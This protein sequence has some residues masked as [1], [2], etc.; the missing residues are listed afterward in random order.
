MVQKQIL[1]KRRNDIAPS[2]IIAQRMPT[3]PTGKI[4]KYSGVADSKIDQNSIWKNI[5]CSQLITLQSFYCLGWNMLLTG[6]V[7]LMIDTS[8]FLSFWLTFNCFMIPMDNW[9]DSL[10]H[11]LIAQLVFLHQLNYCF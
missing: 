5:Y 2:E 11:Y 9:N 6:V 4:K 10:N 1:V 8:L 7:N 3:A